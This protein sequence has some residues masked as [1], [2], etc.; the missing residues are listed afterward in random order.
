MAHQDRAQGNGSELR[1]SLTALGQFVLSEQS[2]QESL[3]RVAELCVRA[4]YGADG[5]G[6]TWVVARKPTTVTAA[7][8]FVRRIDEIQYALDEGPCLEAYS[9]QQMV[10][11]ED[12][13][14][15]ERWPRFTPAAL[16]NGLRGV[17][18][19]PLTVHVAQLGALNI[20]ALQPGAFDDAAVRTAGLFAEQAA[21]V[22][23]NAEA[24]TRAQTT[25]T[26]LGEAL[27]SRAVIDMAKGIIMSREK[28]SPEEAF[29]HLRRLS[30]TRHRKVRE[31]A[32]G[33]VDG[34]GEAEESGPVKGA[35][36]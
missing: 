19:A 13:E 28:C 1:E 20:Y 23:A 12:L 2:L 15:D 24:F 17:I 4:V 29:D 14:R 32:Q 11:V 10:L 36:S 31:I 25:A 6:V 7:G 34:I 5:A 26:N 33:L 18:A 35:E 27:T 30:Q 9:T 3:Q 16:D 8:D 22:L 21:I